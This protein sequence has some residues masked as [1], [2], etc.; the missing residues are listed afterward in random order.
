MRQAA[1]PAAECR[2]LGE[3]AAIHEVAGVQKDVA[4]RHAYLVMEAVRVRC[5]DQAHQVARSDIKT[6]S[7][8]KRTL[9]RKAEST[10][11][12][13]PR[14]RLVYIFGSGRCLVA[15]WPIETSAAKKTNVPGP[16]ARPIP[17]A[18]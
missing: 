3:Y 16:T 10:R 17:F 4:F 9:T 14:R 2:D 18:A 6:M 12:E 11:C 5:N 7:S 13:Y 1:N 8:Q 15:A